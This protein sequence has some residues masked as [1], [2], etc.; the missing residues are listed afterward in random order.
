[1]LRKRQTIPT[2][3]WLR[4]INAKQVAAPQT[5]TEYSSLALRKQKLRK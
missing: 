1:M 5:A 3:Y 4:A 2:C